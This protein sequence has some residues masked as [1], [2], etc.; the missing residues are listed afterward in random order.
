M[1]RFLR[2]LLWGMGATLA[3]TTL[4]SVFFYIGYLA[5]ALLGPMG[6]VFVAV[7]AFTL[8]FS[9]AFCYAERVGEL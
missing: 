1:R 2:A 9:V 6:G 5:D 4:T 7:A 3:F 8:P